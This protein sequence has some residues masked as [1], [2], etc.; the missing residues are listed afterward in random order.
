MLLQLIEVC[1]I[2]LCTALWRSHHSVSV[3]L[4]SGLWLDH[5]TSDSR[6]LW[7][8][9]EFM[10]DSMGLMQE[11]FVRTDLFLSRAYEL[12]KRICSL[13]RRHSAICTILPW[14]RVSHYLN[15]PRQTE[16]VA[17][18]DPMDRPIKVPSWWGNWLHGFSCSHRA[19]GHGES[20][21]FFF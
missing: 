8:P 14:T 15:Q 16:G 4:R 3:R 21:F 17:P 20:F 13:Y 2:G 5:C 1:S 9:E 10:V 12:F 19:P 6:I 11:P 18:E 7:C